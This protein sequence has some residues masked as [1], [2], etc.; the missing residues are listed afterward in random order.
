MTTHEHQYVSVKH[1]KDNFRGIQMHWCCIKE[2]K[3]ITSPGI[4]LTNSKPKFELSTPHHTFHLSVAC[5]CW[6][7]CSLS[8]VYVPVVCICMHSPNKEFCSYLLKAQ[9]AFHLEVVRNTWQTSLPCP[10][11]CQTD[12]KWGCS[13][14]QAHSPTS[15]LTGLALLYLSGKMQGLLS[16][17]LQLV[18]VRDSSPSPM[19]KLL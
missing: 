2:R 14:L 16:Q 9:K 18:G 6:L 10:G 12:K 15:E 5:G 7:V 1:I 17:V 13:W 19:A 4:N 11:H 8:V 3:Q